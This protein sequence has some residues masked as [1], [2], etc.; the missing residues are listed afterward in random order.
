MR[1][2]NGAIAYNEQGLLGLMQ[3]DL[4]T[5]ADA[6][7]RE[8]TTWVGVRLTPPEGGQWKARS[9]RVVAYLDQVVPAVPVLVESNIVR[10]SVCD[11]HF[12]WDE[13]LK[14]RACPRCSTTTPPES[15]EADLVVRMNWEE[16]RLVALFAHSWATQAR[17]PSVSHVR[18]ER[19]FRKFRRARPEGTLALLEHEVAEEAQLEESLRS[20]A[21]RLVPAPSGRTN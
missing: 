12:L 20:F 7:G 3:S 2:R 15:P 8:P 14:S 6:P 10:C 9:P 5:V 21:E 1:P 18:L 17:L 4:P 19:L 11:G 16:A 13:A